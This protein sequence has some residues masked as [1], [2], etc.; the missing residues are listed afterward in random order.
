VQERQRLAHYFNAYQFYACRTLI[1]E[2]SGR[3]SRQEKQRF[4]VFKVLVEGYEAWDRFDHWRALRRL[5]EA[6]AKLQQ[7]IDL[8]AQGFLA[9]VAIGLEENLEFLRRLKQETIDFKELL[10]PLLLDDLFA[11]ARR[12]LQE[13][14]KLDDAAARLYRLVEMRGQIEV[15]KVFAAKTDNFP[16][17]KIPPSLGAEFERRY[18]SP[19][20]GKIKLPLEATYTLLRDIGNDLGKL[21]FQ[22]QGRF[23]N[24]QQARNQ[25]ILAHGVNPIKEER[26]RELFDFVCS[27]I[28]PQDEPRFPKLVVK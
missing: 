11:N 23:N 27:L 26:V 25:S 14:G 4:E 3:L 12:R 1:Q 18:R 13:E 5:E 21:F 28:S 17:E 10:H 20:D 16:L 8:N 22:D 9:S 15:Q 24:L 6:A 2:V 7:L 19:R